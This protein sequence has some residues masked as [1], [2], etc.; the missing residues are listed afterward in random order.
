MGGRQ[1]GHLT[2]QSTNMG[3]DTHDRNNVVGDA[4]PLHAS[5]AA[6][7]TDKR[8]EP[9]YPESSTDERVMSQYQAG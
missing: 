5:Q 4:L 2:S 1:V 9:R 6:T 8:R 3:G 7:D